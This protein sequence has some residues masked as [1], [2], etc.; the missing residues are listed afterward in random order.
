VFAFSQPIKKKQR[1]RNIADSKKKERKK[2][3][4]GNKNLSNRENYY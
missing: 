3:R 2:E 1:K 4:P